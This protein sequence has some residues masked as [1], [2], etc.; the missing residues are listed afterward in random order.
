MTAH[1]RIVRVRRNYNR[2]VANQTLEDY[3]LRFTAKSA[4]R[5]S[6]LRVANT[7][8]GA[9]SFLALEAIGGAITVNYGVTNATIAI[10]AVG[11]VIFLTGLPIAYYAATYGVDIDLLT[12]GAGFGYIGS[13]VTSLIYASFTFLFFAIEAAILSLALELWF[14]VPLYLGYI[15]SSVVVIPL[16]THGITFISRF[17][18]W[19][20]PIWIALHILPF[21]FIAL[22]D[23]GSFEGWTHYGGHAGAGGGS[24]NL[25]T[26]GAAS[27]VVFSLIAQ[28]GEQVD[29]LR[30]LPPRDAGRPIAWW[31]AFLAAGPGWI[32]PGMFKLLAGSFLA[33]VA[34][35]HLV[36]VD[37]AAEPTQMYLV[38][39]QSV[40]SSPQIAL[41]FACT[42]VIISQLKINVTNAYAGSIAWSNFFSRVTHSH[43]GR[44]VWL[45]F[46]VAIALL[47]M[48]LGI[49]RVLEHI[50]GLYSIVA[51]AW[52][53]ALVA[54]L[55]VNK[56][57][58]LSPPFI[59]FKRAH[60]YDI[61]PVGVGAMVLATAAGMLGYSG[62]LGATLQALASFLA[63]L[64]AFVAAPVIAYVTGGKF[65]LARKPWTVPTTSTLRC[66][67]CELDFEPEDMAQ[68]PAYSGPICS[69]CCSLET[70]CHDC[71]KPEARLSSQIGG[72]V[73]RTLPRRVVEAM[74]TD[75]SQYVGVLL[76][77]AAI[78]GAVLAFVYFQVSFE[79]NV[80]QDILKSTLWTVFFILSIIAAIAAWVFVLVHESRRVAE[81]ET[82]RQTELLM[83]EIEAHK[84]T[85]AK[86]QQAKES[87]EAASKAKSRYV[88][89]LS[90]ELR[91]PLNAVVGYAQILERDPA[92]PSRRI[93]AIRVVR[94]NAEYLSG[95]IDGLLDIS[96]IEA[97][98]FDLNRNE[99]RLREFL[100]Q[101]VDMFRLQ[102]GAKGIEFAFEP[103]P[104]LPAAVYTDENRLRQILINLLSNAVKFTDEGR[105]TMRV[106]YRNQVAS[107]EIEDTGIGIHDED[108]E[109]VFQ[110]F[111]RAHRGRANAGGNGPRPH[112]H[113]DARRDDGRRNHRA[114]RTRQRQH[115]SGQVAALRGAAAAHRSAAR[116]PGLRLRRPAPDHTRR[117]RR[118]GSPR[119]GAGAAGAA[120]LQ[121]LHCGER[122]GVPRDGN[123]MQSEP[124]A[125][126]CVDARHVRVDRGA[127]AAP[128][129][130][131]APGDHHAVGRY[132]G[133][134]APA[135]A[136]PRVRRL[137]DQAARS[138]AASGEVPH[139]AQ[140]AM[141]HE[142][143]A[144][145]GAGARCA[146]VRRDRPMQ[147]RRMPAK[148]RRFTTSRRSSGSDRSATSAASTPSSPR[149]RA[150]P[151][152]TRRSSKT[153]G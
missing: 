34:V 127:A 57:L 122:G 40:F 28:I 91:T 94:R 145:R 101:L 89:G 153:C 114:Q 51:V 67:I 68:C 102:A 19:T 63:L 33:Y 98:R 64:T 112:H 3:A 128:V 20:Q 124:G 140:R 104:R 21:I 80:Q 93:D 43:P 138:A 132:P 151:R 137:H 31:T 6:S 150:A 113:Q 23:A 84:R 13:T 32:V 50:L 70:R 17:Q 65:Y 146:G 129:A 135:R 72:W 86:L 99:V 11:G 111:E 78:I 149:S 75:I 60:L 15:I 35:R 7:A 144:A 49:F 97:G 107:F 71:C 29:F 119:R 117:R 77:F 37:K 81:E 27:T 18:L 58:G 44:V 73:E 38:A 92:I 148:G 126:R 142:R 47:L 143:S 110:P 46:N 69:L 36:P 53:G 55:V 48:E 14:G 123:G 108:L 59:E 134:G 105:V 24:F 9:I 125:A 1:Q 106:L 100:D 118:S 61:N 2:W 103:S 52:V 139:A 42:F 5:W 121:R 66:C 115:L 26:F 22:T 30:F 8:I 131:R 130:A 136:G 109:R 39:F 147:Q 90:H 96:K 152:S 62:A 10:F 76:L 116:A 12:R 85:D 4:R 95:L 88:V 133:E 16:V 83:Q 82:Q 54:D 87:A 25:L 79:S 120:R 45:V 74:N 56:P 41:A 141:D